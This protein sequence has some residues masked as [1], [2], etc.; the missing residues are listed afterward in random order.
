MA[1]RMRRAVS[2]A[3]LALFGTLCA[4]ATEAQFRRGLFSESTEITLYP[5][6]LPAMLLPAGN[7]QVEVRNASGASAR[8]VERLHDLLSRQL[9][10]NDSRLTV[11]PKG[12]DVVVAATL[13]DWKESRRNSTKYVSE[14]RQVGTRQ[15]REKNGTI[16]TE[17]VYE[18][19]RNKPSI[20][21]DAVAGLRVEVRRGRGAAVADETVRPCRRAPAVS[22]RGVWPRECSSRAATTSTG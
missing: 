14:K 11:V 1:I 9:T 3:G 10:D 19:G 16:K 17:P 20:V 12:A 22:R 8:I 13:I 7:V 5:L 21:I 2:L 18:Y 15:V 6:D 4:S